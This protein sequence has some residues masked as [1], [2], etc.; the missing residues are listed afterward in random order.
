K[1][2]FDLPGARPGLGVRQRNH[3]VYAGVLDA[4]E[5]ALDEGDARLALSRF[6]LSWNDVK[7]QLGHGQE[8]PAPCFLRAQAAAEVR[9]DGEQPVAKALHLLELSKR[10]ECAQER[11][12]RQLARPL[13]V[14]VARQQAVTHDTPMVSVEEGLL[15]GAVSPGRAAHQVLFFGLGAGGL[16]HVVSRGRRRTSSEVSRSL[17]I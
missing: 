7:A 14:A 17:T 2:R 16:N 6:V 8:L 3:R 5:Q 10:R 11:L 1:R 15:R 4:G 9:G 13:S 12:L